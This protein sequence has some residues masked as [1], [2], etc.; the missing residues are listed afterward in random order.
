M[1]ASLQA[2]FFQYI[3]QLT[4]KTQL[5]VPSE[6]VRREKAGKYLKKKI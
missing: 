4:S 2:I 6:I 1:T 5:V 3:K